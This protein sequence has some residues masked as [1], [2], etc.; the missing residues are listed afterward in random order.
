MNGFEKNL[1][2]VQ[3]QK[4]TVFQKRACHYIFDYNL[5]KNCPIAIIFVTLIS[6]TIGHRTVVLFFPSHLI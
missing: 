1:S 5:N 3:V 4:H 2:S 6:H